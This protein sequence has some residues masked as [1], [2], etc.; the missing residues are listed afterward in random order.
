MSIYLLIVLATLV[1]H[2][3]LVLVLTGGLRPL[4]GQ[5]RFAFIFKYYVACLTAVREN[6][7]SVCFLHLIAHKLELM[8]SKKS[9]RCS[10]SLRISTAYWTQTIRFYS[11]HCF[12][13]RSTYSSHYLQR[14]VFRDN[15]QTSD[16][17]LHILCWVWSTWHQQR[18]CILFTKQR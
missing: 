17:Q 10:H 2:P 6:S 3:Y 13:F 1:L 5:P 14:F 7:T 9:E 12:Q 18:E 4:I 16:L 8:L 11:C 15:P